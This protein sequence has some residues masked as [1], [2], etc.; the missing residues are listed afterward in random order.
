MMTTANLVGMPVGS[1]CVLDVKPRRVTAT[2][3]RLL[4]VV[5]DDVMR[6]MQANAKVT[7]S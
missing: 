1:L 6:D 2:E 7:A 3:R 4:Q 5:A